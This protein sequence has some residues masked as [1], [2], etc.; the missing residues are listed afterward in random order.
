MHLDWGI[1]SWLLEIDVVAV[2]IENK[3]KLPAMDLLNIPG[4]LNGLLSPQRGI[5]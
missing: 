2:R 5:L 4:I 1:E 3:R